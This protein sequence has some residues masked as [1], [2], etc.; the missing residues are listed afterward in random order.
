[1][2]AVDPAGRAFGTGS[3]NLAQHPLSVAET[4]SRST[5][6]NL[7][8]TVEDGLPASR[9]RNASTAGTLAA[10]S[11]AVP[12]AARSGAN[13]CGSSVEFLPCSTS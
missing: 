6:E 3:G 1:V 7:P 5:L 8:H 11:R 9:A 10:S 2:T 13:G 12:I 4:R